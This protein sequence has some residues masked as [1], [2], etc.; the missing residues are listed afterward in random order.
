MI[1]LE[2]TEAMALLKRLAAAYTRFDLSGDVG[3]ERIELW[4]DHL[5]KMPFEAVKAKIDDHIANKPFPPSIAE[6]NVQHREENS[7]LEQQKEWE[8]NAKYGPKH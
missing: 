3:K 2:T 4:M 5:L 8:Q 1:I 7:F 6:V